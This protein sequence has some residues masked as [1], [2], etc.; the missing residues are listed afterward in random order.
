MFCPG[1]GLHRNEGINKTT[2]YVPV[3]VSVV[4]PDNSTPVKCWFSLAVLVDNDLD[5][6]KRGQIKPIDIRAAISAVHPDDQVPIDGWCALI[7]IC[8]LIGAAFLPP[9][10]CDDELSSITQIVPVNDVTAIN[11]DHC[12]VMHSRVTM[13]FPKI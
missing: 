10:V 6:L 7:Y 12:L 1:T 5:F 8:S 9:G 2:V 4:R 11:P 13:V 3:T